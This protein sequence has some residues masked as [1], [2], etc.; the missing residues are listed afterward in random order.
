MKLT[1][2]EV[3][4]LRKGGARGLEKPGEH[5]DNT[6]FLGSE[7]IRAWRSF[8]EDSLDE[9]EVASHL[10]MPV[11]DLGQKIKTGQL[12]LYKF[13]GASGNWL[14]PRWQFT[15]AGLLPHLKELISALGPDVHPLSVFGFMTG[16]QA[17]LESQNSERDYTPR[18]WLA[19]GHPPEPVIDIA[20]YL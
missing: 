18:D 9:A 8:C 16:K 10:G 7:S 6:A 12:I 1:P 14:F 3:Q 17:D 4:I 19:S 13:A 5:S 2:D 15:D 11:D 20:R